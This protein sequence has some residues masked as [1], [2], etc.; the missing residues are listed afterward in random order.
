[1]PWPDFARPDLEGALAEFARRQRRF[2]RI[3][4]AV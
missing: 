1:V 3:R 4:K 2:G